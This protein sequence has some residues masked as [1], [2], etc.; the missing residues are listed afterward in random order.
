MLRCYRQAGLIGLL[1]L[2]PQG[3]DTNWL[4][5]ESSATSL[6]PTLPKQ[7]VHCCSRLACSVRCS[8]GW[9]TREILLRWQYLYRWLRSASMSGFHL[10]VDDNSLTHIRPSVKM[11]LLLRL[12]TGTLVLRLLVKRMSLLLSIPSWKLVPTLATKSAWSLI[13]QV[14]A[15]LLS[16][17]PMR[18]ISTPK[19]EPSPPS[20][21]ASWLMGVQTGLVRVT[22]T[23]SNSFF[24]TSVN[25]QACLDQTIWLR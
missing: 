13:V 21:P 14:L 10:A 9:T 4:C 3:L 15:K 6:E 8:I 18:P 19:L 12:S 25:F 23:V 22:L 7:G 20:V 2:S 16:L 5:L 11:T 24:H 1:T 17:L